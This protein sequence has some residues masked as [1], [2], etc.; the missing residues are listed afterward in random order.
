VRYPECTLAHTVACQYRV[1][2]GCITYDHMRADSGCMHCEL[3]PECHVG[4]LAHWQVH[5]SEMCT[6]PALLPHF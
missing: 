3:R 1:T 6:E 4:I 2:V 5:V